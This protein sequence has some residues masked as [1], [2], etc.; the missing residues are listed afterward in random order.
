M[1]KQDGQ[2]EEEEGVFSRWQEA[3]GNFQ[4]QDL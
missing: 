2:K 3:A 4:T 1:G